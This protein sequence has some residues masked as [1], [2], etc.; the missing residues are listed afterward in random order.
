[1]LYFVRTMVLSAF[2]KLCMADWKNDAQM[3]EKALFTVSDGE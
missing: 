1:M 2:L 3:R